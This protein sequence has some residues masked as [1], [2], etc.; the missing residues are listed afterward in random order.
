MYIDRDDEDISVSPATVTVITGD[1][2]DAYNEFGDLLAITV[3][4]E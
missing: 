4:P 3:L 2:K 1:M